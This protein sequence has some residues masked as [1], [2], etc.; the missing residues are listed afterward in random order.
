[1]TADRETRIKR[2]LYRS[3]STGTKELDSWLTRFAERSLGAMSKAELD[4]YERLLA[5]PTDALWRW[6]S[7]AEPPPAGADGPVARR[8]RAFRELD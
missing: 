5:Q 1:M 7:G 8:L 3:R 2:L 4:E 6:L